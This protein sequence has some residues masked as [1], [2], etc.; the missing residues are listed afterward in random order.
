MGDSFKEHVDRVREHSRDR[1]RF[2]SGKP[3]YT[4]KSKNHELVG[5]RGEEAF[6]REFGGELDTEL[7]PRGD[8]GYDF[9]VGGQTVDVKTAR[10]AHRL[11]V[12]AGRKKYA[13]LFVLARYDDEEDKA[14][15]VGWVDAEEVLAVKPRDTGFGIVNHEFPASKL[16]P[17]WVMRR[18]AD[19][20]KLFR[21]S[22]DEDGRIQYHKG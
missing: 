16:H 3:Y 2:H 14:E 8:K 7:R 6:I 21:M 18:M 4:P 12:K 9:E 1:E 22:Y 19:G 15:L 17:M 20:E 13:D 11:L 5:L 10:N